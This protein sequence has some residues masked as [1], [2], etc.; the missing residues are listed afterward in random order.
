MGGVSYFAP[1]WALGGS[2]KQKGSQNDVVYSMRAWVNCFISVAWNI[3]T[4][5]GAVPRL[6]LTLRGGKRGAWFCGLPFPFQ[7]MCAP[8]T[9]LPHFTQAIICNTTPPIHK[10]I[11][12]KSVT[13]FWYE[14]ITGRRV[15]KG[16]LG[17]TECYR[18]ILLPEPDLA[19]KDLFY[20]YVAL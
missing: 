8:S 19:Y 14:N 3:W 1:G 11:R 17:W 5:W 13:A 7:D 9:L 16:V 6:C 20:I 2:G 12:Y 10:H 4:D 15:K 18:Y